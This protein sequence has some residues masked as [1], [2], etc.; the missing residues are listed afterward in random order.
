MYD[1]STTTIRAYGQSGAIDV[2]VGVHQGSALSSF[3]FLHDGRH[4]RRTHGWTT[5]VYPLSSADGIARIAESNG[6]FQD[7]LQKWQ[8]VLAENGPRLDVKKAKF[9]SSKEGTESIVDGR[10]PGRKIPKKCGTDEMEGVHRYPLRH[11]VL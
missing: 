8:I 1:G 2:T 9:L 3:L 11:S 7:K 4:H 6:V 10:G 5:E